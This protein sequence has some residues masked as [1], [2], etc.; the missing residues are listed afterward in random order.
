MTTYYIA[1]LARYVLVDA[2]NETHARELGHAAL[3][4]L[5]AEQK[6]PIQIRTVRRATN[7]EIELCRWHEESV[8]SERL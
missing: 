8:A 2:D 7:D 3:L 1:T 4:E 6:Q 5:Y